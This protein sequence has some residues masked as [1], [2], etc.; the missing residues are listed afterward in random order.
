MTINPITA[1]LLACIV[2]LIAFSGWQTYR[3]DK[4]R[5]KT[6]TLET[7][8]EVSDLQKEARDATDSDLADSISD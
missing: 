8:E 2:A 5:D 4:C 1:A 6:A 3:L 7:C